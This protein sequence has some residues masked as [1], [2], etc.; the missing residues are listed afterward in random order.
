MLALMKARRGRLLCWACLLAGMLSCQHDTP[1]P[2]PEEVD[3][4]STPEFVPF[5]SPPQVVDSVQ[6]QYPD[7]ARQAGLEG[8]VLIRALLSKKGEVIKVEILKSDAE[9][10]NQP[11]IDAATQWL[12]TPALQAGQPVCVWVAI[13]FRFKL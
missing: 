3:C 12:F 1:L 8:V 7:S 10:F 2:P 4:A 5:D 13:P 11:V 9:I 6:P